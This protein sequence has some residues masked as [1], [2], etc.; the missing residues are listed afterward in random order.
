[1][2]ISAVPGCHR[3]AACALEMQVRGPGSPNQN[4]K[5]VLWML[6]SLGSLGIGVLP[7]WTMICDMDFSFRHTE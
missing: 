1:V 2:R 5:E 3:T 6:R 4:G 7:C